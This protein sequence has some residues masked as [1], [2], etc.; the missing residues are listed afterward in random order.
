MNKKNSYELIFS[1]SMLIGIVLYWLKVD[2]NAMLLSFGFFILGANL[3]LQEIKLKGSLYTILIATV[4]WVVALVNIFNSYT[5]FSILAV[6]ITG[7]YFLK[8]RIPSKSA[9]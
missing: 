1:I 6:A 8:N 5:N 7:Y 3:F 9:L 4:I 2:A